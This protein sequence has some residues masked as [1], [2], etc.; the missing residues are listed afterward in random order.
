MYTEQK[1][2]AHVVIPLPVEG[3]FTYAVPEKLK[4]HVSNGVQVVVPFGNR[5][6]AGIVLS[7]E[8]YDEEK[9]SN[10]PKK[11][12]VIK[13][14]LE[15]GPLLSSEMMKLLEWISNYYICYPGEAY[16]LIHPNINLKKGFYQ[17][18]KKDD[19]DL[20]NLS[21]TEKRIIKNLTAEKWITL[22]NLEKKLG[23]KN[24]L[25]LLQ[26][27]KRKSMI[28]ID[29]FSPM[30]KNI[31]RILEF[32]EINEN[33]EWF[34]MPDQRQA[35]SLKRISASEKLIEFLRKN[36][37]CS[38]KQL[39]DA[40]F[41]SCT[42]KSLHKK[43]VLLKTE[44]KN[45][46][47]Q[48]NIFEEEYKELVPSDKQKDFIQKVAPFITTN[49][50]YRPFLLHGITGSG[51]TQIYIELIKLTLEQKKQ[52]IVLL[53][54]I[55]LTPQ[56]LAR[57]RHNFSDTVAVLHSR[58]SVSERAEVLREIREG[59][60]GIVIGP[61]SAIFAP[62]PKLGLIIVDE[63]H[64]GSYKQS[65][66]VPR[67]HAR[68][69]AL[70][71]SFLNKIPIILGSATPSFE[72]LFNALNG[73]YEY[74]LLSDRI[75]SRSLPRT[76]I[77]DLKGEWRKTGTPPVLS[78][79]LT[80][81]IESRLI[82]HEQVMMLQNRRGFAP[83]LLCRDC[84]YIEKCPN[85]DITLTY[86]TTG[87]R[88]RCHYCD[89]IKPAPDVCPNCQGLDILFKGYGTQ[90]IERE[91]L[92]EFQNAIIQRMDQDTTTKK[93]D[94]AKILEKFRA[95][96]IDI[97]VG[98]KMIAKGLDFSKVSL[99][100]IVS[101]D[102]GLNFPDFRASEKVFQLLTQ[103]AG[104]AGRGASSG[105]VVIQTFDPEH[106]IFKMLH[107]HDYLKFY[108]REIQTRKLLNYPPFSRL[109]LI[110]IVG[111]EEDT[112]EKYSQ[113]ISSYLWSVNQDKKFQILGPAPAPLYRLQNKYRYHILLKQKKEIDPSMKYI[114]R[115]IKYAIYQNEKIKK[116]PVR[117]Q[118]DID[119]VEI[120]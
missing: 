5:T 89:Y 34:A 66:S 113:Y 9:K 111:K 10:L 73:K 84:G 71:R 72:S 70:Y 118:I 88:L 61:R 101:A 33:S 65:D 63:E 38:R 98:T 25:Y 115:L 24:I 30:V 3:N 20:Q 80:L 114:R 94:H 37:K 74:F 52:A 40:G 112:V 95:G 97:L 60:F 43:G 35:K 78:D 81:K 19:V 14:V 17:I 99:V 51:K 46:R 77:V 48:K 6:I 108:E 116:W 29:Y 105:E 36:G 91:L 82:S 90:K 109:C 87:K 27:L 23:K 8:E 76:H 86:H 22:P 55:V 110:R 13:D 64:E 42:I 57:F 11:L 117:I 1:K 120:M 45:L 15:P 7:I 28:E 53:P 47:I 92:D 58:L 56:T 54:E 107:T 67:Y 96:N 68:D 4:E 62:L 16:R 79:T 106:Y 119:P 102:Q 85:C 41:Q 103:A 12:K 32:F 44:Q 49:P 39:R 83:Y 104:R 31:Y 26:N 2:I 93:D 21:P 100:G 75:N 69:V 18:R 50:Q 59:R